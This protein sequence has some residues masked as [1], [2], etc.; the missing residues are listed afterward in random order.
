LL[1]GWF[2]EIWIFVLGALF[3]VVTLYLPRGVI[4]GF[5]DLARLLRPKPKGAATA[6]QPAE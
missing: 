2:P 5:S 1:T 4:G 3:V 6:A